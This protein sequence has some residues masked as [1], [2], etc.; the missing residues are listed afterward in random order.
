MRILFINPPIREQGPPK[1]YPLGLCLLGAVL[2]E[3]GYEVGIIDANAYRLNREQ[4]RAEAKSLL[5][6]PGAETG[7][8]KGWDCIGIGSL[9]TTYGWQKDVIH[10]L[11]ADFP[12][13]PIIAGGG[14]ATALGAQMLEW[15]PDLDAVVVG[16]A[17]RTILEIA[18]RECNFDGVKGVTWRE[19][20]TGKIHFNP[21]V[22]LMTEEDFDKLPFPAW[23]LAPLE[24]VYFP[25]SSVALSKEALL[26][27]RRLDFECTRGCPYICN[28]MCSG[29]TLVQTDAGFL[30]LDEIPTPSLT[31]C[32]H[33]GIAEYGETGLLVQSVHHAA[34]SQAIVYAGKKP[35]LRVRLE[36]GL[37]LDLTEEHNV[38]CVRDGELKWTQASKLTLLDFVA[39]SKGANLWGDSNR[40]DEGT[41]WVLGYLVGDGCLTQDGRISF[42]VHAAERDRLVHY[43]VQRQGYTPFIYK[44]PSPNTEY[45]I[46]NKEHAKPLISFFNN[47]KLTVPSLIFHSPG[48][49]VKAFLEGLWEADGAKDGR[50]TTV[51]LDL[52]HQVQLLLLNLGFNSVV[53]GPYRYRENNSYYR[54]YWNAGRH[55]ETVPTGYATYRRGKRW[56][57]AKLTRGI[58][59]VRRAVLEQAEPKHPLLLPGVIYSRVVGIEDAGIKDVYDLKVPGAEAFVGNG[60]ILHNCTDMPTGNSR[61]GYQYRNKFRK[62]SPKYVADM[63]AKARFKLSIDFA[64]FVDENFDVDRKWVFTLCD[65]LE[66]AELAGLV[67]WGATAHVNTVSPDLL[68]RMRQCGCA[69]LDYG[70]ESGSDPI[71]RY[72]KKNATRQ[73]NQQALDWSLRA[74]VNPLTNFMM[75]QPI[76]SVQTVY[77]TAHFIA[78]NGV[79]VKPFFATPYPATELYYT[80]MEKIIGKYGTLEK[81]MLALGDATDLAIN[82]TRFNDVEL[83]GL[84]ELVARHDLS[85]LLEYAKVKG[86]KIID[87]DTGQELAPGTIVQPEPPVPLGQL[88]MLEDKDYGMK[89]EWIEEMQQKHLQGGWV[90]HPPRTH[91]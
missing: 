34:T 74:N 52:A 87:P 88:R 27:K 14:C 5:D 36:N 15:V 2:D 3:A 25:N 1:H 57:K 22:E 23:H 37:W 10:G 58:R 86:E 51:S 28:F 11:R 13:T 54:V 43:F 45:L 32:E 63:I 81:F 18:K 79:V 42:V 8:N 6:V 7:E 33:G 46:V 73:R 53:Q 44:H 35:C 67:Y 68:A 47:I 70:M 16:E 62:H 48:V 31:I 20:E 72:I 59:G 83:F 40:I 69:Y 21:P 4:V 29:D 66:D 19:K 78:K 85:G 89:Q 61:T 64:L 26:A 80:Q 39:V 24:E 41:A 17:E 38:L 50:L 75:G 9:I 82:L 77:D 56:Q 55:Y 30:R 12:K 71:L 91:S 76:E 90:E 84:R 60:V 49:V 65:A